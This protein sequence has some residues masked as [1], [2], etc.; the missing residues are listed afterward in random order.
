MTSPQQPLV[1]FI[2]PE[3]H[4]QAAIALGR[5]FVDDPIFWAI[6]PAPA[7]PTERASRIGRVFSV[8]LQIH[9]RQG[10]PLFGI[11][12]DGKVVAAAVTEGSHRASVGQVITA[13]WPHVHRL[14]GAIGT[15]GT[16]RALR[17]M[18]DLSRNHP[19]QP[20]LYLGMLGV[21]PDYQ[22]RHYGIALLDHL[23]PLAQARQHLAAVY[24]ETSKLA[25]VAYY[26][27]AG[28]EVIGELSPLGVRTW[29][30]LQPRRDEA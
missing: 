21:D 12:Q 16:L 3:H 28:Y 18:D 26:R 22:K 30:M 11:I 15:G 4:P 2:F 10:L 7:D 27:R 17:I 23:A 9:R 13:G 8:V 24:L 19:E 1:S 25:N 14:I 20:H 6:L 5:A 29:R